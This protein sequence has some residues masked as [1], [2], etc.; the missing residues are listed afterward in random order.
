LRDHRASADWRALAGN[1]FEMVFDQLKVVSGLVDLPQCERAPIRHINR[2]Q[3]SI[4]ANPRKTRLVIDP[5]RPPDRGR[6]ADA[7]PTSDG[8]TALGTPHSMPV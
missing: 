7:A 1:E 8:R 6:R 4:F 5:E 2:H 3:R